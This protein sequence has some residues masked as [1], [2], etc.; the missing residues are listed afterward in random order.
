MENQHTTPKKYPVARIRQ[1]QEQYRRLRD[2]L[3]KT[4]EFTPNAP[5]T[6]L[7][8]FRNRF[9][10]L[11]IIVLILTMLLC[12]AAFASLSSSGI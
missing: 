4:G 11:Y 10:R 2:S 3:N 8:P 5:E 7:F 9:I 12:V 6:F 1:S